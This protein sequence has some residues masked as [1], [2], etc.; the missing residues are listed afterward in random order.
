[1]A[2]AGKAGAAE[3]EADLAAGAAGVAEANAGMAAG[4]LGPEQSAQELAMLAGM[5]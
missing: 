5:A 3:A 4:A 2:E 1:V